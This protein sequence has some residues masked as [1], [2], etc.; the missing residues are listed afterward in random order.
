ME[1]THFENVELE[2]PVPIRDWLH[3]GLVSLGTSQK[4]CPTYNVYTDGSKIEGGVGCAFVVY[5][6]Q[7]DIVHQEKFRLAEFCSNNQAELLAIQR[8]LIWLEQRYEQLE[9][10]SSVLNS[11]SRVSLLSINNANRREPL[12]ECIRGSVHALSADGWNLGFLWVKA[13]CGVE[14]NERADML[15]KEAALST[16]PV[17]YARAP[18]SYLR[19]IGRQ[20][21]YSGW[22]KRWYDTANGSAT[23]QYF[24]HFVDRQRAVYL[25]LGYMLTQVLSEHG[26][27][28]AYLY[29]FGLADSGLCSCAE[30][31][32]QTWDHLIYH[33]QEHERERSRLI[34]YVLSTGSRWSL[35]KQ[36]LISK[37]YVCQFVQ[38]INKIKLNNLD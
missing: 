12:L 7:G 30:E 31:V 15:A 6:G 38:F 33:C 10:R 4:V 1:E 34:R 14:G 9:R 37:Q 21:V 19:E 36:K 23:K 20:A 24:P 13:H 3:P 2:R 18:V 22:E 5:N 17:S 27:H 8:A 29:R 16:L 25:P 26:K 28:R 32:E 11:D 35:Q